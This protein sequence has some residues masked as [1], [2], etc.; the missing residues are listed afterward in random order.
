MI[1]L[2]N[3]EVGGRY[4]TDGN[5]VPHEVVAVYVGNNQVY[6]AKIDEANAEFYKRKT[7]GTQSVG[8]GIAA[9]KEMRGK[10]IV[11]NQ[12]VSHADTSSSSTQTKKWCYRD[13]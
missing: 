10:S 13:W 2:G 12:L 9:I 7:G 11:W 8:S 4:I 3:K 6:S 5:G 1:K